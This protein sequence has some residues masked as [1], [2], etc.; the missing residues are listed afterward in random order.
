MVGAYNAAVE[1]STKRTLADDPIVLPSEEAAATDPPYAAAAPTPRSWTRLTCFA[2]RDDSRPTDAL[3]A[4][5]GLNVV[6]SGGITSAST[7]QTPIS[8]TMMRAAPSAVAHDL[9]RDDIHTA[10]SSS[11]G[12]TSGTS[13]CEPSGCQGTVDGFHSTVTTDQAISKNGSPH[14]RKAATR[15]TDASEASAL[16]TSRRPSTAAP[17][18][19]SSTAG[20]PRYQNTQ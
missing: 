9:S 6:T 7:Q 18:Q 5:P 13:R 14:G 19:A 11:P 16:R 3:F 2:R 15:D 4:K 17:A 12:R 10:S 8:A 20:S 1:E